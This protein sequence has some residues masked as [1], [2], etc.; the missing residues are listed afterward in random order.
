MSGKRTILLAALVAALQ[1]AFLGWTILSR[2]AVL[3]DGREVVLQVEPVDPRDLLRGDYVILRY[4]AA[5]VPTRLFEQPFDDKSVERDRNVWVRLEKGAD[6]AWSPVDARIGEPLAEPP[7]A[8]QVDIKGGSPYLAS[9]STDDAE[10]AVQVDYGVGRYYVP[11]GQGREI[12]HDMRERQFNVLLAVGTDGQAQVK[13][14][15][16]GDVKLYEEPWY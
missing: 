12:E 1:I 13:A 15:L 10:R 5:R 2:A 11:E 8:G 6:G 14:L 9:S 3:R 7:G 4:K 16:D